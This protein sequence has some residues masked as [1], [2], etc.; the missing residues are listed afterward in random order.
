MGEE[1]EEEAEGPQPCRG[2]LAPLLFRGAPPCTAARLSCCPARV[3]YA[4]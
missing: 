4:D 3:L 2:L 1:E